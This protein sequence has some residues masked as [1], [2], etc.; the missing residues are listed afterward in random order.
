MLAAIA[1]GCLLMVFAVLDVFGGFW[2]W[3]LVGLLWFLVDCLWVLVLLIILLLLMF[4][5]TY[6][7][8]LVLVLLG[9]IDG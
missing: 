2:G 5:L 8:G 1:G 7:G 9:L 4:W 6:A 3:L